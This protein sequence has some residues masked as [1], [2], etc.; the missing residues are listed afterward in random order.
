MNKKNQ[1]TPELTGQ[2]PAYT[3][4]HATREQQKYDNPVPSRELILDTLRDYAGQGQRIAYAGLCETF[5]L[6]GEQRSPLRYRL[7]AMERDGQV[8]RD[9]SHHYHVIT[10]DD[11]AVG[12]VHAHPKGFGFLILDDQDDWRINDDQMSFAMHG[13]VVEAIASRHHDGRVSARIVRIVEHRAPLLG[14]LT[15]DHEGM[16]V[17]PRDERVDHDITIAKEH[18]NGATPGDWV[19]IDILTSPSRHA[20]P[21]GKV[22]NV[23]GAKITQDAEQ[24]IALRE[25]GHPGEFED[26][27]T[28]QAEHA[29][30]APVTLQGGRIDCRHLP[31][32]TIDGE[33]SRDLDDAVAIKKTSKGFVLHVAIADVAAYVDADS[34][35]NEAVASRTES[36]YFPSAVSAMLPTSLS[37]GACSLN[38]NQDRFALMFELH[39]DKKG[40]L[41]DC[42]VYEALICSQH[43]TTYKEVQAYADNE[44]WDAL[45]GLATLYK[46]Y[47]LRRAAKAKRGVLDISRPEWKYTFDDHG[48]IVDVAQEASLDSHRVIEECMILANVGATMFAKE[49]GVPLVYRN[50]GAFCTERLPAAVRAIQEW[51]PSFSLP[52]APSSQDVYRALLPLRNSPHYD[53]IVHVLCRCMPP[54]YYSTDCEGHTG[55]ALPAYAHVTSP[56]RRLPDLLN[57]RSLKAALCHAKGG[58]RYKEDELE[59]IAVRCNMQMR[60]NNLAVR[61][62]EDGLKISYLSERIG[63]CFK[64]DV[65][66]ITPFGAFVRLL[67]NGMEGLLPLS[68]FGAKGAMLSVND[69]RTALQTKHGKSLVVMGDRVRIKVDKVDSGRRVLFS[70]L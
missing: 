10:Q 47:A 6:E 51:E 19:E 48:R 16:F 63:Q 69:S 55:L 12:R 43:R 56:I 65:V 70:L 35:L 66:A 24:R 38:A 3:D 68:T 42:D 46:L 59:A 67:D 28:A 41:L 1:N 8:Y 62:V 26:A 64:G 34:A 22:N 31:L 39:V 4:P 21:T 50:H 57:H 45:P 36:V 17:T 58:V 7:R 61:D 29:S 13:D 49:R 52:E 20:L 54:A 14:K 60:E 32:F 23:V 30:Q 27:V 53:V 5:G 2:T 37:N 9:K 40:T 15:E 25:H 33:S 18:L 11:K 44:Q